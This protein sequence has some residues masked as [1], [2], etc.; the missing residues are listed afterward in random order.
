ME[1]H[2]DKVIYYGMIMLLLFNIEYLIY[3]CYCQV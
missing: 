1:A 2:A 3:S